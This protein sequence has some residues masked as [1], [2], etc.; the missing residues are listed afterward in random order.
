MGGVLLAD[1]EPLQ[2]VHFV[3]PAEGKTQEGWLLRDVILLRVPRSKLRSDSTVK[4]S[5]SARD[6]S[7]Q[8]TGAEVDDPD[9]WVMFDVSNR[10]TLKLVAV[11][12]SLDSSYEWVQ[13]SDR[14]EIT[15]P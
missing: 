6:K 8:L 15:T 11:L 14:I 13:D 3:E 12:E 5:S 10:G 4:V 9:N 2:K 7:A 1:L